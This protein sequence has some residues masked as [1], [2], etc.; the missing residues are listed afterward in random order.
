MLPILSALIPVLILIGLGYGLR[1]LQL[2]SDDSW[3]GLEKLAYYVFFPALLINTLARQSLSGLPWPTIL[4]VVVTTCVAA[5]MALIVWRNFQKRID[6][7]TFTSVFQGGVRFNSYIALA[8]CSAL[9]GQAGLIAAAVTVAFFIVTVNLLSVSA[10]S[11][12]ATDNTWSTTAFLREIA[13]NPLILGCVIGLTLNTTG[14]GLGGIAGDTVALIGRAALPVGLLAVG[15]AIKVQ[16][17]RSHTQPILVSSLVQFLLKPA[18][19][20]LLI[21]SLGL[22]GVAA[23]VLL[24]T[25][26]TPVAPSSYILS[27]QLG[28]N[29]DVMASIIGVQTV[30]AFFVLPFMAWWAA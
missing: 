27:R 4:I 15:A 14:L 8:V 2:V 22:T 21:T 13:L 28:G 6:G 7:P 5:A 16:D 17:I 1:Q 9:Y 20:I 10:L 18:V 26:V 25:F 30:L 19:V 3:A 23:S 24:L 11:I 12:W 29:A